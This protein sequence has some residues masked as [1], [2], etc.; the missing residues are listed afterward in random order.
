MYVVKTKALI[1]FAVTAK[2]ICVFVFAYAKSRFSHH[3]AQI[4]VKSPY[5]GSPTRVDTQKPVQLQKQARGMKFQ[6]KKYHQLSL[7]TPSFRNRFFGRSPCYN[8]HFFIIGSCQPFVFHYPPP[9]PPPPL[10]IKCDTKIL[11]IGLMLF[12]LSI[13]FKFY[14]SIGFQRF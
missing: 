6:M 14:L 1:S 4:T 3:E 9:P 5:S 2:L 7:L 12:Y 8:I 13:C 11:K 10:V